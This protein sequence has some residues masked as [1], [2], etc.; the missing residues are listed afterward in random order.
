MGGNAFSTRTD[1]I[2]TLAYWTFTLLLAF[3]NAA[4]AMWTFLPIVPGVEQSRPALVF[5]EYQRVMLAHLGYPPYFKYILGPWQFGA[6]AA[7]LAPR[8]PRIQE[9]AYAGVFFNYSSALISH[10]FAGDR[11]QYLAIPAVLIGF[12]ILSWALRPPDRRVAASAT[13]AISAQGEGSVV[14][15]NM[16]TSAMSWIRPAA[17]LVLLLILS[18]FWLPSIPQ[19]PK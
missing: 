16:K 2:R 11:L 4:G 12:T 7:L 19:F 10:L 13:P 9:W 6:A 17:I 14:R 18:L 1:Q 15:A 5:A 3:E 8:V